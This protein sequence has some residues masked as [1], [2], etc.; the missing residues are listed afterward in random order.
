MENSYKGKA[1]LW[2]SLLSVILL[3]SGSCIASSSQNTASAESFCFWQFP[4]TSATSSHG[5]AMGQKLQC[6][7]RQQQHQEQPDVHRKTSEVGMEG[8]QSKKQLLS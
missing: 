1:P 2:S 5:L 7:A 3:Y 4:R 8:F 6:E